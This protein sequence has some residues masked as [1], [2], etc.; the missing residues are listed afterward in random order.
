MNKPKL[1]IY[2]LFGDSTNFNE[3]MQLSNFS[4]VRSIYFRQHLYLPA[5]V[6]LSNIDI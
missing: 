5:Y 6:L 2:S 4:Q 1:Y 3:V